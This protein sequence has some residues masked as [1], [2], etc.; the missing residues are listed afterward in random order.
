MNQRRI[1]D[2]DKKDLY[3]ET[4]RGGK[5]F[6]SRDDNTLDERA[7]AHA[8][9]SLARFCGNASRRDHIYTVAEHSVKVSYLVPTLTAL[10]HDAHEMII[11]DMPKP[12]K[13]YLGGS[14]AALEKQVE[15]QFARIF[16]LVY[17][18]PGEIHDADVKMVMIEAMDLMPSA[19][20]DWSY[21]D[22][23]REEVEA[24]YKRAPYLRPDCW[25][26][27]EAEQRFL[28]RFYELSL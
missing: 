20:K 25:S 9:S 11:A 23:Y 28:D 10:M 7:V 15:Q 6:P 1:E 17:P 4:A 14:Y 16:N 13:V 5:W 8:L 27:A 12:I 22:S 24:L 19:G 18:H 21:F 2:F 26:A 3:I